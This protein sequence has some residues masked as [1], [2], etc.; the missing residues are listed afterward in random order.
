MNRV[1]L[2]KGVEIEMQATSHSQTIP[3][4]EKSLSLSDRTLAFFLVAVCPALLW[5]GL[6]YVVGPLF[7][8]EPTALTMI[9]IF[10]AIATF[11]GLVFSAIWS[12]A[13]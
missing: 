2:R 8:L 6:F 13:S 12:N 3:A 10:V 11:I 5:T 4:K 7:G 9:V 1:L